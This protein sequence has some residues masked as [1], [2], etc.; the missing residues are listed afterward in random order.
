[1]DIINNIEILA[2]SL[3]RETDSLEIKTLLN[4]IDILLCSYVAKDQT[5][6]D[7]FVHG[8]RSKGYFTTLELLTFI[9]FEKEIDNLLNE[10]L[11]KY[12]FK[13]LEINPLLDNPRKFLLN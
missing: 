10:G 9:H 2:I 3:Y 12:R 5:A 7:H 11:E 1:M 8:V 13:F 4:K 6:F